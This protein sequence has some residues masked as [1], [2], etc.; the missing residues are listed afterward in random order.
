[1]HYR[2]NHQ[3]HKRAET[4]AAIYFL[5]NRFETTSRLLRGF[6]QGHFGDL[7]WFP[8]IYL[9]PS[10]VVLRHVS[11]RLFESPSAM[12]NY[13]HGPL[14]W[15]RRGAGDHFSY[16]FIGGFSGL[17]GGSWTGPPVQATLIES[18]R[19]LDLRPLFV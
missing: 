2:K 11:R 13:G 1:V 15:V 17:I 4:L 7:G 18:L 5:A 12:W 19:L 14:S 3:F 9:R 6:F 10:G 8:T 16:V